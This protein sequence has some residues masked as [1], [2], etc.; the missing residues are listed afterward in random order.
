MRARNL[1]LSGKEISRIR[2]RSPPLACERRSEKPPPAGED[3]PSAQK[4]ESLD[5]HEREDEN[6]RCRHALRNNEGIGILQTLVFVLGREN[7]DQPGDES[8]RVIERADGIAVV[9]HDEDDADESRG[10]DGEED[11]GKR[12]PLDDEDLLQST[13][14][15]PRVCLA[16]RRPH[17]ARGS[18]PEVLAPEQS[19]GQVDFDAV[20]ERRELQQ[21]RD[22]AEREQPAPV[23]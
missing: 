9:Q 4:E 22:A 17:G 13:N 5:A 8:V 1:L 6:R 14:S 21:Q 11:D 7:A 10:E 12:A 19:G 16:M 23:R 15:S 20:C 2:A 3:V 18:G